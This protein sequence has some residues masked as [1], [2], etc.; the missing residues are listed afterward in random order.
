MSQM[1]ITGDADG[2]VPNSARPA[3]DEIRPLSVRMRDSVR[4]QLDVLAQLNNRSVT[5]ETRLALEHWVEKA[6]T[7]P[8]LKERA[9]RVRAE[10]DR[11]VEQRRRSAERDAEHRRQAI[12]AV[13]GVDGLPPESDDEFD[14]EASKE[15]EH[16]PEPRQR[17]DARQAGTRPAPQGELNHHQGSRPRS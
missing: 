10:I 9:D 6:K 2:Y 17:R 3:Y 16:D 15:A 11:E 12:A 14:V 1:S 5:E 8:S 13:L 4:A 7:D